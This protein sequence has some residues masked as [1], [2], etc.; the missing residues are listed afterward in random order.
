MELTNKILESIITQMPYI[1][2]FLNTAILEKF[3]QLSYAV[4]EHAKLC[5]FKY[6]FNAENFHH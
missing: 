4:Y 6:K 2:Q 3:Q 1:L 5:T